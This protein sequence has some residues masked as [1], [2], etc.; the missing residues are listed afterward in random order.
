VLTIGTPPTITSVTLGNGGSTAGRIEKGDTITIRFSTSMDESSL[1]P[2]WSGSGNQSLQGNSDVTVAVSNGSGATHDT[3]TV[4]SASCRGFDLGTIDLGSS[5]Y[6]SSSAT[7]T[8]RGSSKSKIGYTASTNTL[9]VTLGAMATGSVATVSSST[10]VYAAAS[11]I[12][13]TQAAAI[14]NSPFTLG[15]ARQF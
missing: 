8:G 10:P 5:G 7:F 2:S 13:D 3:V 9:V 1:C 11:T 12:T 14:A 15:A 4:G 6:V